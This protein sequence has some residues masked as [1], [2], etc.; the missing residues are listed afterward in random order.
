MSP[1]K[2]KSLSIPSLKLQALVL[3]VRIKSI[4]IEQV[5]FQIDSNTLYSGSKLHYI[6]TF[7]TPAKD[8]FLCNKSIKWN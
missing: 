4:I 5:D 8:V 1:L 3:G 6:A 2:E 7:P